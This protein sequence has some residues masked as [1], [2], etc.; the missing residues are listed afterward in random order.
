MAQRDEYRQ[1][2]KDQLNELF[3]SMDLKENQKHY[4]RGRWMDQVIWMEGRAT[5]ARDWYYRLRLM[6]IMGGVIIPILVSLNFNENQR[7]WSIA[8]RYT[9]IS[10]GAIVAISSAVEE[11]FHYGERWRHY[12]RSVESLKTQGWQFSQLTGPYATCTTHTEAFP[13][14][15]L[16]VEDVIQRDV[17]VY[18]TQVVSEQVTK[19]KEEQGT[20][21]SDGYSPSTDTTSAGSMV[22]SMDYASASGYTPASTDVTPSD[23]TAFGDVPPR[24]TTDGYTNPV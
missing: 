12:R 9:T 3:A 18:A 20:T 2:L 10:L 1:Q 22:N 5:K 14:F 17:E 8:I 16:Q 6:T 23:D 19:K 4:M 24:D 11:F 7:H 21:A 13:L 15:S